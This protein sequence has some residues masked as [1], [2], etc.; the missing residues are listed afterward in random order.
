MSEH[1]ADDLVSEAAAILYSAAPDQFME[2][3]SK[4][5]KAAREQGETDSAKAITALRRPTAAAA[6]VNRH[7]RDLPE[8]IDRLLDMGDR[9]RQAHS[10]LDAGQ[11]REL[12]TERRALVAELS[13]AAIDRFGPE[14]PTAALR[15][16]V[17]DTFDA[18]VADPEIAARLGEL[19]RPEHW[20]GFGVAPG[21]GPELTL[22]RGGKNSTRAPRKQASRPATTTTPTRDEPARPT[23]SPAVRRRSDRVL[24]KARDTFE[25]AE[26]ALLA[27]QQDEQAGSDRVRT[28][29]EQLADL[30]RQLDTAKRALDESRRALKAARTRRREARSA[31][32]R[33]ERN[34]PAD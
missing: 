34:T 33:A 32:D 2:Q 22:V 1:T 7:V 10:A 9:L 30:S 20:S 6:V 15:D 8:S 25:A 28:L 12:S 11:L 14:S 16:D 4:L 27:A 23:P 26:S 5:S 24:T 29:G 13:R 19:I 18:A 21:N 17:S 3:R 31:L